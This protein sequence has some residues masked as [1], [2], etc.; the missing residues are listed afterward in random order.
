M[1]K[2]F[3]EI[4][5]ASDK[6]ALDL[7]HRKKLNFNIGRYNHSVEIGKQQYSNLELAKSRAAHLKNKT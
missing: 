7:D 6:K 4:I 5:Y 1:A 3:E 2:A